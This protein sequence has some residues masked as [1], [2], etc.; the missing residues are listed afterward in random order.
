MCLRFIV[1]ASVLMCSLGTAYAMRFN[2]LPTTTPTNPAYL[3]LANGKM[4][5]HIHIYQKDGDYEIQNQD[6]PTD[7][8]WNYQKVM[9]YF[10]WFNELLEDVSSDAWIPGT[11]KKGSYFNLTLICPNGKSKYYYWDADQLNK[12]VQVT[13]TPPVDCS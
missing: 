11:V 6:E 13:L 1:A 7:I 9:F 3:A 8:S 2:D 4:K 12:D 10:H 5:F